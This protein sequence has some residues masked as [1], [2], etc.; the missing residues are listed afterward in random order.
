MIFDFSYPG[1]HYVQLSKTG[2]SKS[3]IVI[4]SCRKTFTQA[5]DYR[6]ADHEINDSLF[7]GSFAQVLI[8]I[9]GAR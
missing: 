8:S 2:K 6:K 7:C 3:Y 1:E 5:L 4:L 9:K